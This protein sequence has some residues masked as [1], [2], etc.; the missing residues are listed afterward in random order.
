MGH[1]GVKCSYLEGTNE[2][3]RDGVLGIEHLYLH[4]LVK[5]HVRMLLE[6]VVQHLACECI[7]RGQ[8]R[9]KKGQTEM[10]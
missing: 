2:S 3:L 7:R 6:V 8:G 4:Y 1:D 9:E 10:F 5:H